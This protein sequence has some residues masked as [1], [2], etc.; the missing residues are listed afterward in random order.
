MD[1]EKLQ[2]IGALGYINDG[3]MARCV[4]IGGHNS[5]VLTQVRYLHSES[6]PQRTRFRCTMH[7]VLVLYLIMKLLRVYTMF[8]RRAINL[9]FTLDAKEVGDV[10]VSLPLE[11]L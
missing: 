10:C 3:Y 7:T 11:G 2:P 1:L 9:C 4:D 5:E 8:L 6:S